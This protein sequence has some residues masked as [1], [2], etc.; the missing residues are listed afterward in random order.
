[1]GFPDLLD[2]SNGPEFFLQVISGPPC[3]FLSVPLSTIVFL[4]FAQIVR[5]V[6]KETAG[7]KKHI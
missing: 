7:Y 4:I 5:Q 2:P 3:I 1:M 6:M